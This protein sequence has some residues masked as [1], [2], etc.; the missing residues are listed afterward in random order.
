RALIIGEMLVLS[1]FV[2]YWTH[3]AAHTVPALWRFHAVHHSTRHLR[4][5]SALRAHP[6]EAYVHLVNVIPLFLLGY[7][8]DSLVALAPL[9]TGYAFVIHTKFDVAAGFLNALFNSPRFHGWHHA[10]DVEGA[11]VNFAGFFPIWD[12]L[13]GTYAMPDRRPAE[14]GI[15]DE[16][17]PETCLAQVVHPFRGREE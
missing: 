3:R 6:A 15:R 1:D 2:Y 10:R 12:M 13:F 5:T 16:Q 11:G 14:V 8:I 4:W 7:P 17:M 9:I